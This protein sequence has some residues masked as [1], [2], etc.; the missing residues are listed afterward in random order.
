MK[1]TYAE[2]IRTS[3]P[4]ILSTSGLA[5]MQFFDAMFLAWHSPVS[6]AAAGS[7][8]CIAW[9]VSCFLLGLVCYT[10]ALTSNYVGAKMDH[11]V[12]SAIW[13]GIHLSVLFG[14][15]TFIMSFWSLWL[16][17]KSGHEAVLAREEGIY[18][19]ILLMGGVFHF[20]QAAISGFFSGRKDNS[21]LMIATLAGHLANI[22]GDYVLIFGKLGFPQMGIAGAALATVLSGAISFVITALMF[23]SKSNRHIYN[24]WKGRSLNKKMMFHLLK[25]GA[26]S[27]MLQF[28]D[29][30]MWSIFLLMLGRIGDVALAASTVVFRLNSLALQPVIG[31]SR[32]ASAFVGQSHGRKDHR[33][34]LANIKRGTVLAA[35]FM[36][37]VTATFFIMPETYIKMFFEESHP[38]YDELLKTSTNLL[39]FV[40]MYCLTDSFNVSLCSSLQTVGDTKWTS[41]IM[42]TLAFLLSIILIIAG[43]M[44]AGLYTIWTFVTVYVMILP[45]FWIWR[46]RQGK[47]KNIVVAK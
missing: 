22:A 4:L 9:M 7:A 33:E 28:M 11:K 17:Q 10:S 45:V 35:A 15:A 25:F 5:I 26:P 44:N 29:A 3:I 20:A 32:A 19:K 43:C 16:F 30:A 41:F 1:N 34:T 47:W 2:I 6:L 13:Q 37:T 23:L 8:G 14:I 46:I 12:G 31:I 27:G 39:Y 18:L 24:T 42:S 40:S 21:R 38:K 36:L